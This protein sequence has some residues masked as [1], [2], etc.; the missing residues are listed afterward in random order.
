MEIIDGETLR[1][2]CER[3]GLS[4]N[5][6]A[7]ESKMPLTPEGLPLKGVCAATVQDAWRNKVTGIPTHQKIYEAI[8]SLVQKHEAAT[9]PLLAALGYSTGEEAL[10]LDGDA[11]GVVFAEDDLKHS[12]G[13]AP[14][15]QFSTPQTDGT[16]EPLRLEG[17]QPPPL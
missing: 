12:V 7:Q 1:R 13:Q 17:H 9:D 15:T 8:L 16:D 11:A 14:G 6:I 5:D 4:A 10:V 2:I 3:A